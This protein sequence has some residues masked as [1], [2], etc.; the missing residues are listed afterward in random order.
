MN[1]S[2][3]HVWHLASLCTVLTLA[4]L[5][6]FWTFQRLNS[7][8]LPPVAAAPPPASPSGDILIGEMDELTEHPVPT[9]ADL[10]ADLVS[11]DDPSP[12]TTQDG[13]ESEDYSLTDPDY[14][15]KAIGRGYL[16]APAPAL[17]AKTIFI[18]NIGH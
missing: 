11:P 8:K 13:L 4:L 2:S 5:G 12:S 9:M 15:P 16:L 7:P 17:H 6:A 3:K 18:P 1:S 10:V 14:V